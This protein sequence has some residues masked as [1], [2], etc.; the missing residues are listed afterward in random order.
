MNIMTIADTSESAAVAG[1]PPHRHQ[2]FRVLC[3][4]FVE[5]QRMNS[6]VF[7]F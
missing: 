4:S 2:R 6:Y 5:N 1:S 7:F 3:I